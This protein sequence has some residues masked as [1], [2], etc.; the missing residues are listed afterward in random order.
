MH[1]SIRHQILVIFL[2]F[3]LIGI[4]SAF[5][6]NEITLDEKV[7]RSELVIIGDVISTLRHTGDFGYDVAVITPFTVLKGTVSSDIRV[8]FNGTLS[9]SRP[10]CCEKGGRYL[11]F[12]AKNPSGDYFSINGPYGIFRIDRANSPA[13][14]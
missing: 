10:R 8:A 2:S 11:F 1:K 5:Q 9:E 12:I 7:A 6:V 4:A 14:P 3:S 13:T